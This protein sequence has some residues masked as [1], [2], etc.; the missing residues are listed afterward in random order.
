MPNKIVITKLGGPE[1]LEY[2]SYDIS[3]KIED[4]NVRIQQTSI[5]L[6]YI[7]TYHRSGLYPLPG[8]LPICPGLEASGTIIGLGKDV[9]NFNIGDRVCYATIPIGAYC[10]IRDFPSKSVIKLPNKFI[11]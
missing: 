9:K 7:D 6:N 4:E 1:V 2:V 8:Q 5:G 11:I 3:Q 10:E